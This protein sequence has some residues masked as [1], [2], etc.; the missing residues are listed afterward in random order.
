[1]NTRNDT[2]SIVRTAGKVA[3]SLLLCIV[4][5]LASA[6][7]VSD[8][9]QV[10]VLKLS[11]TEF[12]QTLGSGWRVF[13]DRKQYLA[14]A[15]LIEI[16]LRQHAELAVRQ[17][18]ISNHHAGQMFACAGRVATAL[19]HLDRAITP[20]ETENMP[21]DW[22]EL[23]ISTRAFLIGDRDELIASKKRVAAMTSP[24]FRNN[25]DEL[26]ENFGKPYGAWWDR[27]K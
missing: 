27:E 25:A 19:S 12:D 15:E 21:E 10:A 3:A 4:S 6:E 23:V 18:A 20:P 11:W 9:E 5:C 16:Y 24:T 8:P 14:A 2:T 7:E 26:L 22:N 1:M 13:A 17:R